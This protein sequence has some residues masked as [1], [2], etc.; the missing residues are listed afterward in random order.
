MWYLLL[1]LRR[2]GKGL[3]KCNCSY[4]S[5][6]RIQWILSSKHSVIYSQ[7]THVER[8][9]NQLFKYAALKYWRK[10]MEALWP[11]NTKR[12]LFQINVCVPVIL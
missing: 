7:K 12:Y 5:F 9:G 4:L 6:S 3:K 8:P 1:P 11:I 2:Q 10:I